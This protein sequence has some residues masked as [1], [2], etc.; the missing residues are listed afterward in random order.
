MEYLWCD[1]SKLWFSRDQDDSYIWHIFIRYISILKEAMQPTT[2]NTR[3][4]VKFFFEKF[5]IIELVI[6][7][8]IW[9]SVLFVQNRSICAS[10]D[11]CLF[12]GK[13]DETRKT[14]IFY[15]SYWKIGLGCALYAAICWNSQTVLPSHAWG[16]YRGTV[17]L[18][19]IRPRVQRIKL[20]SVIK[21]Q[22]NRG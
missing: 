6:F 19:Y 10:V 17:N 1:S 2:F 9:N 4:R 13:V 3:P 11:Q 7:L 18:F 20:R 8:F 12:A 15:P 22:P 16:L 21:T 14:I 5:L